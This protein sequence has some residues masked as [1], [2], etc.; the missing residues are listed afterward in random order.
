MSKPVTIHYRQT[1]W[2]DALK[3]AGVSN[4]VWR[5]KTATVEWKIVTDF[6][7]QP[8]PK[9]NFLPSHK[10]FLS[11]GSQAAITAIH[12]ITGVV[13][14]GVCSLLDKVKTQVPCATDVHT[15]KTQF[16]WQKN[17]LAEFCRNSSNVKYWFGWVV[18]LCCS[19]L[20]QGK[21][22]QIFREKAS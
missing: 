19:W 3:W 16:E 14:D 12:R 20:L 15:L 9:N 5:I 6:P 13:A 10:T 22:T 8:S 1:S 4:W 18:C 17:V 21:V 2:F 11:P 7:G